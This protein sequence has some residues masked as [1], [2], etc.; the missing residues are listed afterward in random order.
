MAI[1]NLSAFTE[2]YLSP[3]ARQHPAYIKDMTHSL[4]ELQKI[5]E[6]CFLI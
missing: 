1:E 2:Y 5:R 6:E 4:T 3:L